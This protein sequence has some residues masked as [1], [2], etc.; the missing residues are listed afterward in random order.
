LRVHEGVEAEHL[1][2][3]VVELRRAVVEHRAELVVGEEGAEGGE[4]E[5]GAG[6]GVECR[7]L[8]DAAEALDGDG[9]EEGDAG[10]RVLVE[11]LQ[12]EV[13]E[14]GVRHEP[15]VPADLSCPRP[16]I[17]SGH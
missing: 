9:L 4:G 7:L 16:A 5:A 14:G 12:H 3:G 15:R 13:A 17:P 8:A 2:E 1:R 10:L 6:G 11:P